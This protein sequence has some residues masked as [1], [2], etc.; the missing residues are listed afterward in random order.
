MLAVHYFFSFDSLHLGFST[1]EIR[2]ENQ[3]FI[4]LFGK[5]KKE[6][7]WNYEIKVS[8]TFVEIFKDRQDT[9]ESRDTFIE[10]AFLTSFG[11]RFI[12]KCRI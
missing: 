5:V 11:T 7:E 9:P 3:L 4:F 2:K 1:N 8:Y 12:L 6:R 10:A